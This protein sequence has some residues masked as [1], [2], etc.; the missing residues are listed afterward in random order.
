MISI[1]AHV[2]EAR[3]KTDQALEGLRIFLEALAGVII[4][5]KIKILPTADTDPS[6][7]EAIEA[8]GVEFNS[9]YYGG[10]LMLIITDNKVKIPVFSHDR[11][12]L[13]ETSN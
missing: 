8:K 1:K 7:V 9:N 6:T 11:I 4:D 5:K 2:D 13:L 3:K 10:P 12:Q